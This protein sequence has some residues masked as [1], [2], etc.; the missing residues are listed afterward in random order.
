MCKMTLDEAQVRL[1]D[2]VNAAIAGK[3]VFIMKDDKPIV[4]LISA[5]KITIYPQWN[6][7]NKLI[8]S[9]DDLEDDLGAPL[10]DFE[11][12][13]PFS[14]AKRRHKASRRRPLFKT[15]GCPFGSCGTTGK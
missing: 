6:M 3:N 7:A 10:D 14:A 5:Q 2:L 13:P 9:D 12:S 4:Q 11:E 1:Q 15:G 8:T